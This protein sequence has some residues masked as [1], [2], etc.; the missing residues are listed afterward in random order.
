MTCI[1]HFMKSH[2]NYGICLCMRS[3]LMGFISSNISLIKSFDVIRQ[4]RSSV[5]TTLF[6]MEWMLNQKSSLH[7]PR[8][9]CP[10]SISNEV[11]MGGQRENQFSSFDN[12]YWKLKREWDR[13]Y[14]D[15]NATVPSIGFLQAIHFQTFS[16]GILST[17]FIFFK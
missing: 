7:S 10:D 9:F 3:V 16:S 4:V 17:V 15:V 6:S 5:P 8:R 11:S 13:I 2:S 14:F 12:N 1:L